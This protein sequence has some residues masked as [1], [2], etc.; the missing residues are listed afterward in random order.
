MQ[1]WLSLIPLLGL[2]FAVNT[3]RLH[4]RTWAADTA[5]WNPAQRYLRIGLCLSWAGVLISL[6]ALAVVA[7][8]M[9]AVYD[10]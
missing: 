5:E 9:M 1:G 4:F 6:A 3:I 10:Y 7:L 2:G 8:A